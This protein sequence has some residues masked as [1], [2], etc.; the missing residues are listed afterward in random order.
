MPLQGGLQSLAAV[1]RALYILGLAPVWFASAVLFLSLWPWQAAVGHL[2][3]LWLLGIALT[4]LCLSGFHKIPF[5]CFYTPGR[6]QANMAVLGFLGLLFLTL[7]AAEIERHA[8][9]H[10]ASFLRIVVVLLIWAV[11]AR[12]RTSALAKSPQSELRFQD[13]PIPAIFALDLHRDGTPPA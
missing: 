12:W 6:S 2:A 9:D 1:R 10:P 4:K 8:L 5:T 7:K 11:F 3:V 13:E